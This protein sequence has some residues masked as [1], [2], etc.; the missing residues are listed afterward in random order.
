MTYDTLCR[1]FLSPYGN[2]WVK[3]PN[4]QRLSD[5][6]LTFDACFAGSLPTIPARREMHTGRY[7]FL[8][9]GW[10]PLEPF[11]DSMPQ[12]LRDAGVYTHLASDAYHYWEDGGATYHGRYS[13]WVFFRGQESDPWIGQ[14]ADPE[15][16]QH[17]GRAR[18]QYYISQLSLPKTPSGLVCKDLR[19]IWSRG[20]WRGTIAAPSI[21][22]GQVWA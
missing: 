22:E 6:A 11:D 7:N 15:I 21:L 9:R 18:R 12:L 2:D 16:P 4:F 14:V 3:T 1:R 10:G 5:R 13:S 17:I 8:H 20:R 19:R